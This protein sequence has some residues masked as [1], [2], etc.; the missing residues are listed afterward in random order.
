MR[1]GEQ[2]R[3]TNSRKI[4]RTAATSTAST[5]RPDGSVEIEYVP[6]IKRVSRVKG[7]RYPFKWPI[8][9]GLCTLICI[10]ISWASARRV[11]KNSKP[12]PLESLHSSGAP[13]FSRER[14]S[15]KTASMLRERLRFSSPSEES[16]SRVFGSGAILARNWFGAVVCKNGPG[17]SSCQ[18]LERSSASSSSK[19][20]RA[21]SW[22]NSTSDRL[23][24]PPCGLA[25]LFS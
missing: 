23:P 10:G 21:T 12:D 24:V 4:R 7:A 5:S 16:S 3:S 8:C 11:A 14:I 9:M 1:A 19:Q 20:A 25:L 15:T 17:K 22:F 6:F 13:H 18:M 2:P